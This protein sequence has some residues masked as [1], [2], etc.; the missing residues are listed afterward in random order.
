MIYLDE[1]AGADVRRES[2]AIYD[3]R[4]ERV[5]RSVVTVE[6]SGTL[7]ELGPYR[8]FMQKEIFEQPRAVADTLEGVSAIEPELFGPKAREVLAGIDSVLVLACG[9]S[10]Y[11]GQVAKYWVESLA[12]VPCQVEIASEYRYRDTVP[13][14]KQLVIVVSQSGET[15]DTLACLRMVK[16]QGMPTLAL[17]NVMSSSMANEADLALPLHAGPELGVASTKAF[18]AQLMLLAHFA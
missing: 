6:A 13:N 12:R 15:A 5:D 14:P 11:A 7:V 16:Q 4:G 2:F 3:A 8:H 10:Q 9:T 17:V 1:G 18:V